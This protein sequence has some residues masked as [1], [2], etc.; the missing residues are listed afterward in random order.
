MSADCAI[1]RMTR[2]ARSSELRRICAQLDLAV[3]QGDMA[4]VGALEH[5]VRNAVMAMVGDG[6]PSGPEAAEELSA[7]EAAL[8]VL[9]GAVSRLQE[10]QRREMRKNGARKLYLAQAGQR[11]QP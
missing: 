3:T 8:G 9:H 5:A 4:R 11:A 7:L 6:A 1:I 10:V 2:V